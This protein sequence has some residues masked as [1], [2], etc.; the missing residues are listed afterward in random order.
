MKKILFFLV[1]SFVLLLGSQATAQTLTGSNN[2]IKNVTFMEGQELSQSL[3]TFYRELS[4]AGNGDINA[5]AASQVDVQANAI[6]VLDLVTRGKASS[7]DE[8]ISDTGSVPSSN[9]VSSVSH[10]YATASQYYVTESERVSGV[11]ISPMNDPF[12]DQLLSKISK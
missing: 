1:F 3:K 5:D 12:L 11:I 6:M 2:D 10:A 4:P 9:N 7:L 8:I